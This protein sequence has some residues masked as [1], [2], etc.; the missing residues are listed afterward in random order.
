MKNV[1][2]ATALIVALAIPASA[3]HYGDFYVIPAA[4][5]TAGAND[6][7]FQTDLF[8]Q[9]FNETMILKLDIVFLDSETGEFIP[10]TEDVITVPARGSARLRDLVKPIADEDGTVG[11]LLVG[12]NHPFAVTSRT[13]NTGGGE[14]TYGQTIP[15]VR[16]FFENSSG[17]TADMASTYLPGIINNADFRTNLGLVVGANSVQGE[18][19]TVQVRLLDRNGAQYGSA[20]YT[21]APGE[22]DQMQVPISSIDNRQVNVAGAVVT[23]TSGNGTIIP[24]LSV[25]DNRTGDANFIL[26]SFPPSDPFAKTGFGLSL[27]EEAFRIYV[28]R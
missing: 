3:A 5:H 6:T 10:L 13:Y 11:A 4:G 25:V 14:G 27:F 16:D 2:I 18:A 19:L 15:G 7:F 23:V 20:E 26:G 12:G 22:F 9:N 17:M 28:G 8:V 21:F 1:L 24:Y